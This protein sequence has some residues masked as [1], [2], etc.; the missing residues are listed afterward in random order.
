VDDNK[1]NN[2]DVRILSV[3]LNLA[4]AF[5]SMWMRAYD[6]LLHHQ[7]NVRDLPEYKNDALLDEGLKHGSLEQGRNSILEYIKRVENGIAAAVRR[8]GFRKV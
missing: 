3:R 5:I 8:K 2:N 1:N 4:Q 6:A 7:V